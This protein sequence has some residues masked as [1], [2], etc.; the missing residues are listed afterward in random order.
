MKGWAWK[1]SEN[2]KIVQCLDGSVAVGC[3]KLVVSLD[4]YQCD[5]FVSLFVA[6]NNA[7]K[8]SNSKYCVFF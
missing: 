6:N 4:W 3:G 1:K 5:E 8:G 2:G 7:F